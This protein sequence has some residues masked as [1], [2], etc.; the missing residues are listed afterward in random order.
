MKIVV[1]AMGG[2]HAP[3]SVVEG[4]VMAASEYNTE[5]ILTGL[6]DTVQAILDRLD[7]VHK[8]TVQVVHAYE[9]VEMHD[10]PG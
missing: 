2:D 10:L 5:I 8:L 7:P 3:E 4:A 9:V 1:D 6:S